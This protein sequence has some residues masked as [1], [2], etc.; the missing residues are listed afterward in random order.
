MMKLQEPKIVDVKMV[1][2]AGSE[3]YYVM[4]EHP[5]WEAWTQVNEKD[6]MIAAYILRTSK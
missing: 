3:E 6:Y 4:F 2:H 1:Q 5:T